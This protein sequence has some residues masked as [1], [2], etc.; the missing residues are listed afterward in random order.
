M[1]F[2]GSKKYPYSNNFMS[3]INKS[4]G[5]TNAYTSNTN[6]NYYFV[7]S[8]DT[9]LS[10]LDIFG[11]FLVNPLLSKKYINKEIS[12][13]NSES[14]KNIVDNDWLQLEIAKTLYYDDHPMN[15]YRAGTIESLSHPNIYE[16][17]KE[18]KKNFYTAERM[19]L[20][21]FIN[22]KINNSKLEELFTNTFSLIPSNNKKEVIKFGPPLKGNQITEYIPFIDSHQLRLIF[23]VKTNKNLINSPLPFIYYLL[24]LNICLK[25]R[26][27]QCLMLMK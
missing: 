16:K 26:H 4:G 23:Q 9:Y 24:N 15:H 11:N 3:S 20:V 12:N 22:D 13:V 17:L 2:M 7:C 21:L 8:T 5:S 18:F 25:C 27:A 1:L 19:S 6:T 14:N 10:N